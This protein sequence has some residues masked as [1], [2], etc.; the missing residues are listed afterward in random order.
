MKKNTLSL[1]YAKILAV[2][3]FFYL[4]IVA[5]AQV[6]FTQDF[7]SST[8]LSTYIGSGSNQFDFIGVNATGSS[9]V[10]AS[11]NRLNLQR[12]VN[13]VAFARTTDLASPAPNV[14][15]IKFKFLATFGAAASPLGTQAVVYVGSDLVGAANTTGELANNASRHSSFGLTIAGSNLFYVR[16]LTG[17]TYSNGGTTPYTG[18]QEITWFINNSGAEISYSDPAGGSSILANDVADLWVGTTRIFTIIS[19]AAGADK[20][21]TDFKVLFSNSNGNSAIAFDD[22]EISIPTYVVPVTLSKFTAKKAGAANQLTWT[23]ETEINNKGYDV[24]RQDANGTWESLGFVKGLDKPSTYTFE[25]KTPLSISYYRLRQI[26]FDGK[27]TLSKVVSVS[28]TQK[29]QIRIAPNPASDKV[30]ISLFDND[31]LESTT[32]TVYDLMGRQ[33]LQQKT[34]ANG[35]ELDV[36]SLAKGVYLV[37]INTN[38]SIY[39]EKIIRQ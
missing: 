18:Q 20:P 28:Q 17:F 14:L 30:R 9:S 3:L 10:Y 22:I 27:E 1:F 21:L 6:L 8:T 16:E 19:P 24:E 31:R 13:N 33:V 34:T 35:L 23:T 5:T 26:D 25:D 2:S 4:P 38:N 32:V 37:K 12:N 11:S 36:S 29:G 39:T 7:N 15:K